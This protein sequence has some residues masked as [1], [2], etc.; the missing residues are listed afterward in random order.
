MPGRYLPLRDYAVIGGGRTVTLVAL[1]GSIDWLCLPNLDSPSAFAAILDAERGGRFALHPRHSHEA[2][3]RCLPDTNVLETTF[4]TPTGAVRVTDAMTLPGCGLSPSREVVRRVEGLAGHVPMRWRVEPRFSYGSAPMRL[5]T[6]RPYPVATS[7]SD[8]LA[9]CTWDAGSVQCDAPGV[10]AT[11][12]ARWST[13]AAEIDE[14][15]WSA[16]KGSYVWYAGAEEL[17][18]GLLLM[19][20]MRYDAPDSPRLRGTVDA[21][22]RELASGALLYRYTG[23]DGLAGGEGA[24]VCCSFWLAEALAI[25]GRRK[26]AGGLMDELLRLANDVGL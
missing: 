6:R 21:V 4:T 23:D 19:A 13:E 2:G 12:A 1:D 15:C 11:Y 3:R 22:R 10:P 18:A 25:A 9:V 16:K 17:D 26:E 14:R 5:A 24:F 7:G 8:A 20:I